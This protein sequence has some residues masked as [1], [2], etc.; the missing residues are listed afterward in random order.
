MFPNITHLELT[1]WG[2]HPKIFG[3]HIP[4]NEKKLGDGAVQIVDWFLWE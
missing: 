2:P 3:S 1:Q 4:F